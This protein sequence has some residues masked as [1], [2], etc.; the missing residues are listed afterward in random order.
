LVADG[1]GAVFFTTG[2]PVGGA[3]SDRA[4]AGVKPTFEKPGVEL[5]GDAP[6]F[7]N[8]SGA[9]YFSDTLGGDFR[10][11]GRWYSVPARSG[12]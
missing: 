9:P 3:L 12:R 7:R 8:R 6:I 5:H 1:N 2:K 4:L 10:A 11:F